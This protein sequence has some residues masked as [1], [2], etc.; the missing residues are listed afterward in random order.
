MSTSAPSA[1]ATSAATATATATAAATIL[2]FP[3]IGSQ[4]QLKKAVESFW[5]KKTSESALLAQAAS[6]RREHWQLQR[7]LGLTQVPVGDFT[8]YD[9]VLDHAVLFG[10]T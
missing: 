10:V 8:L 1:T 2:G 4:R 6:L 5:A 3:R 7:S 9:H